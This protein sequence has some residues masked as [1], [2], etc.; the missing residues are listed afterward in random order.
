MPCVYSYWNWCDLFDW[1]GLSRVLDCGSREMINL[2]KQ[3]IWHFQCVIKQIET[4][5]NGYLIKFRSWNKQLTL[6][7]HTIFSC[8]NYIHSIVVHVM[9]DLWWRWFWS[10][11]YVL[12]MHGALRKSSYAD[13][14]S[15][16]TCVIYNVSHV[17]MQEKEFSMSEFPLLNCVSRGFMCYEIVPNYH[18]LKTNLEV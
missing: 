16:C 1:L 5:E 15:F 10:S 12:S 9:I 2:F 8:V 14:R 18:K 6:L 4:S 3:C 11:Q 13:S 7:L 17:L